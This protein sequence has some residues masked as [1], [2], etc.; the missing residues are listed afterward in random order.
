M[1][2]YVCKCSSNISYHCWDVHGTWSSHC[3]PTSGYITVHYTTIHATYI[4]LPCTTQHY[5]TIHCNPGVTNAVTLQTARNSVHIRFVDDR[6][7]TFDWK[8]TFFNIKIDQC[9]INGLNVP[10]CPILTVIYGDS[11]TS[12]RDHSVERQIVQRIE[13][14][15]WWRSPRLVAGRSQCS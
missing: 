4:T 3:L 14:S 6:T 2:R 1:G 7:E 5:I 10:G 9:Y 11:Y 13:T 12:K 8:W 15:F